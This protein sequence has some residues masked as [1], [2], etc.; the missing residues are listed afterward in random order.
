ML[1][2]RGGKLTKIFNSGSQDYRDLS[3]KEKLPTLGQEEA[4]QILHRNGNLVKRPFLIG[5]G[6][7]LVGFRE[8]D[9]EVALNAK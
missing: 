5:G 7:S 2:A 1:L 6:I 4:F 8:E 3:L 9:W